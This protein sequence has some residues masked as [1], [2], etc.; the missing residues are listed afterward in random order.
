M[1]QFP[2][3]SA[4]AKAKAEP[5]KIERVTSA[6]PIRRPKGLGRRFKELF[7]GADARTTAE[8]VALD[9]VV[10]AIRDMMFEAFQTGLERMIY[11]E[12]VGKP[13]RPSQ[14]PGF[15]H[16]PQVNYQGMSSNSQS[17]PQ[18]R[19]LSQGARARGAFDEIIIPSRDEANEVI[20]RM[21]DILSH[22]GMVSVA[23]LYALT[24]IRAEHT[25]L[26][27]GWTELRGSKAIGS[28]RRGGYILDLPEPKPLG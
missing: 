27:W 13:R 9:V 23:D 7:V 8:Y 24:G 26:K 10:P 25:D 17:K 3:N 21:F 1:D 16:G 4:A 5:R 22:D 6:D 15:S 11:G 28:S 19:M 12:R 18:Q 20:D 14:H 2:A